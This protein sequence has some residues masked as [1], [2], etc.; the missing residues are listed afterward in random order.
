MH[1]RYRLPSPPE[2]P[3]RVNVNV[4]FS[5]DPV[6]LAKFDA[7]WA[8]E[9]FKTRSEA[10]AYLMESAKPKRERSDEKW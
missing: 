2:G 1:D 6:K 4:T 9:G 8:G 5:V 7:W 10:I 3:R